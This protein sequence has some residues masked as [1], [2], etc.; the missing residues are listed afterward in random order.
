MGLQTFN[1]R[2]LWDELCLR[3]Q[4]GV[5]STR[6]MIKAWEKMEPYVD[7][8]RFAQIAALLKIQSNEAAWWR[9][10]CLLYFGQFSQKPLPAGVEKPAKSLQEYESMQ[11]KYVPGIKNE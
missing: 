10:A 5:D 3:Y 2:T 8:Q 6:S 1:G 4:Q 7:E 9:D 11:F